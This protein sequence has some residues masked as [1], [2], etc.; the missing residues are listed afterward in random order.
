MKN[1]DSYKIVNKDKAYKS[2]PGQG[3]IIGDG[4]IVLTNNGQN[5]FSNFPK[6]Y[7]SPKIKKQTLTLKPYFNINNY[8]VYKVSF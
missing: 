6:S 8:D 3:P 4:D 5:N 2:V 1:Q 7:Q